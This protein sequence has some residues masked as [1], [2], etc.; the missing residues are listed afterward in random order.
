MQDFSPNVCVFDQNVA[1]EVESM[2]GTGK[3]QLAVAQKADP[4][5]VK[6]LSVAVQNNEV[7]DKYVA[8]VWENGVLM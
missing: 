7:V 5:L 6:C 1:V 2:L 3:E 4:S 8:Y